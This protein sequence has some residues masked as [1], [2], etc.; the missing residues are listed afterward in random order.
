[1]PNR[2]AMLGMLYVLFSGIPWNALP[3]EYGSGPTC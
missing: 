1:M 2:R 3:K